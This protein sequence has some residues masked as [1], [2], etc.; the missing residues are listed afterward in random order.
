[1]AAAGLQ[2]A[3]GVPGGG[4]K[5]LEREVESRADITLP[6]AVGPGDRLPAPRGWHCRPGGPGLR[7][8]RNTECRG[9]APHRQHHTG[10]CAARGRRG[11]RA[12]AA[13]HPSGSASTQ[14]TKHKLLGPGVALALLEAQAALGAMTDP[15]VWEPF[16]WMRLCAGGLWGQALQQADLG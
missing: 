16:P 15:T 13:F 11:W 12:P 8:G 6:H 14:A 3:P 10:S 5:L 2:A 9:P 7:A 4:L 1:M